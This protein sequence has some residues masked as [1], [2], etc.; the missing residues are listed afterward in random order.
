MG[1]EPHLSLCALEF[2][3]ANDTARCP[4]GG[5]VVVSCV[6]GPLYSVSGGQKKQ[7][8]PKPQGE[9]R[10]TVTVTSPAVGGHPLTKH[11]PDL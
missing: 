11:S 5:P 3:R 8:Q 6:A 4:G 2:Y 1:T 9:V 10:E 7:Q